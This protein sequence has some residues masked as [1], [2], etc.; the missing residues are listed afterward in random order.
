LFKHL[1]KELQ[2][3]CIVSTQSI[4]ATFAEFNNLI[5]LPTSKIPPFQEFPIFD[6]ELEII[7]NIENYKDY[8]LNKARGIGATEIILRWI[9]FQAITNKIPRRK[10]LIVTGIRLSLAKDHIK[11]I[12][13]MCINLPGMI[14]DSSQ[15]HITINNSEIIAIP[16]N[17]SAIRGYENVGVIYSDEAAHWNLLNDGPVLEAIEPHRTK[18]DAHIIIVSTPNGRRGFFGE[19]FHNPD[20]KYFKDTK[21]WSV[22]EGLLIDASKVEKI[23]KEDPYRF[24]QEYNCKFFST[25][26]SAIPQEILEKA[27]QNSIEY[28]LED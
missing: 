2:S 3:Q 8:A 11:R 20:T 28:Q 24:E 21:D 25:R 4:P 9:L 18:S 13:E 10:F 14:K 16:A 1:K 6:Y 22:S 26:Y 5:G 12:N 23:K 27:N 15:Y 17:P 7:S 19:I